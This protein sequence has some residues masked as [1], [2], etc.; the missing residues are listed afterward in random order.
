M[1]CVIV[2]MRP[3]SGAAELVC[4]DL[5]FF[6]FFSLYVYFASQVGCVGFFLAW[7]FHGLFFSFIGKMS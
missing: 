6:L 2:E 5:L 1:T 3:F 4:S 7:L